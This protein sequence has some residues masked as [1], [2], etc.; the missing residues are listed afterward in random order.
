MGQGPNRATLPQPVMSAKQGNV[1]NNN[2]TYAVSKCKCPKS[3]WCKCKKSKVQIWGPNG[4]GCRFQMGQVGMGLLYNNNCTC[5]ASKC[6]ISK[7]NCESKVKTWSPNWVG[8]GVQTGQGP[9][10]ATLH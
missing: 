2:C 9:K 1:Y 4:V 3:K 8:C 7:N 5:D 10:G 6:K